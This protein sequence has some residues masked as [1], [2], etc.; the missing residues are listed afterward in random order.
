MFFEQLRLEMY[1]GSQLKEKKITP[2]ERKA[3]QKVYF[4]LSFTGI[5]FYAFC[6]ASLSQYA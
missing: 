4:T 3:H 5:F 6:K 2:K 1:I